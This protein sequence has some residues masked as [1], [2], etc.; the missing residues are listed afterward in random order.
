MNNLNQHNQVELE[1]IFANNFKTPKF[2][3]LVQI[4]F[5]SND[6]DRAAKVCEIGL[7]EHYNNLD[8]RYMLAKIYLLN[9]QINKSE[10]FL[11]KS[12]NDNLISIKMLRLFIEIRDS[13]NRSK[14][15]TK[16]IVDILLKNESDNAFANLWLHDYNKLQKNIISKVESTFKMNKNIISYTFYN[17]L[18]TQKYYNQAELVLD[19]LK[20]TN[21][22]DIKIY[23]KESKI[24]SKL[25]KS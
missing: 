17:V 11:S 6:L 10:Q 1:N 4:Y 22:I 12:L 8:A 7:N 16:K 20:T 14:N 9:N 25:L 2:L 23:Q 18:K 15:E 19:M 13:L 5:E 24:I 21:K 3:A